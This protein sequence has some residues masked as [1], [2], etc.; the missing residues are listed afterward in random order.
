MDIATINS[1][2]SASLLIKIITL[3]IIIFY[4]IF[5]LIVSTQIKVMTDI[6]YIPHSKPIFKTISIVNIALA[7]LLFLFALVIL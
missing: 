7:I 6:L 1:I 2:S 3:I 5:T 4:I